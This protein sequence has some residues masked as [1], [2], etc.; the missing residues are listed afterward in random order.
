[1]P[2]PRLTKSKPT[3]SNDNRPLLYAQDPS[4]STPSLAPTTATTNTTA[5]MQPNH[6]VTQSSTNTT[7]DANN[8]EALKD[9]EP[10][11]D[12]PLHFHRPQ[13]PPQGSNHNPWSSYHDLQLDHPVFRYPDS[14]REKMYAKGVGTLSFL[15]FPSTHKRNPPELQYQ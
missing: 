3:T 10:Q 13:T 6:D 9:E 8:D 5:T 1:M 7:N 12:Q 14:L 15:Q 2:F 11:N 4:P